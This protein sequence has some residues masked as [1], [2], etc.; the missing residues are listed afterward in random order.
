VDRRGVL[1]RSCLRIHRLHQDVVDLAQTQV[2]GLIRYG[3]RR[4]IYYSK[5]ESYFVPI[6]AARIERSDATETFIT[7][8][9]ITVA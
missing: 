6:I 2:S 3:E 8:K 7:S 9:T 1:D 5:G 4:E